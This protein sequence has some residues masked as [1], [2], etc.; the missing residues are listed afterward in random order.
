M[1][2]L[3]VDVA[4][5]LLLNTMLLVLP[6]RLF[7]FIHL[8]SFCS[9]LVVIMLLTTLWRGFQAWDI[10]HGSTDDSSIDKVE[11]SLEQ[12]KHFS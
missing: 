9:W 3:F 12:Q 7:I 6:V 8:Y 11:T 5:V 2:F 10:L 4:F 1:L